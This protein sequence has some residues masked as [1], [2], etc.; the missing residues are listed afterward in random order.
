M[1]RILK[2]C[3]FH[4]STH[5]RDQAVHA[6]FFYSNSTNNKKVGI[7]RS[8]ELIYSRPFSKLYDDRPTDHSSQTETGSFGSF[9]SNKIPKLDMRVCIFLL[10]CAWHGRGGNRGWALRF[11]PAPSLRAHHQIATPLPFLAFTSA[12]AGGGRKLSALTQMNSFIRH[13]LEIFLK[14]PNVWIPMF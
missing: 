7:Y 4:C 5:H 11:G 3:R 9:T 14:K 6:K 2:G 8:M 13:C 12:P 10:H 1:L